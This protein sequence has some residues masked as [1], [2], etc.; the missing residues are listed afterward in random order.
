[1][2]K[3]E[4]RRWLNHHVSRFPAIDSWLR[5]YPMAETNSYTPTQQAILDGWYEV[6]S[7]CDM[8][9]AIQATD[10]IHAG[11]SGGPENFDAWPATIANLCR[12][13]RSKR[14][15]SASSDRYRP[16]WKPKCEACQDEGVRFGVHPKT[17]DEAVDN[18]TLFLEHGTIYEGVYA[19]DRCDKGR[20][21]SEQQSGEKRRVPLQPWRDGM[22]DACGYEWVRANYQER[23]AIVATWAR[24]QSVGN[25]FTQQFD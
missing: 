4:F 6:L 5:R 23:R 20:V 13:D 18:A 2:K 10:R 24:G 16:K 14:M 9:D 15:D 25:D 11:L 7:M 19:C 8:N 12:A 21:R 1:M 22:I 3:N 17:I